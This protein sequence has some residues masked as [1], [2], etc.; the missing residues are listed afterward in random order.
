MR[1]TDA[2]VNPR[3]HGAYLDVII[4]HTQPLGD[5]V[6]AMGQAAGSAARSG[7]G[8]DVANAVDAMRHAGEQAS[9]FLDALAG[10]HCPAYLRGADSA[11]Q[12]ALKLQIDGARRG[13]RSATAGDAGG[14]I[15]AAQEMEVFNQD[16]VA[17]EQLFNAWRSDAARP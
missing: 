11:L 6:L 16:A 5:A 1:V 2:E 4:G 12:D 13:V 17:A 3:Q 7:S 9:A 8:A 15:A 10:T 14:L